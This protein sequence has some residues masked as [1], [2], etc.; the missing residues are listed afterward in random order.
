MG[1]RAEAPLHHVPA[2]LMATV[3]ADN[4]TRL[5]ALHE[6]SQIAP[7]RLQHQVI[8]IVEQAKRETAVLRNG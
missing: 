4:V 7:R 6:L 2:T 8:V 1:Y 3:E 5:Q